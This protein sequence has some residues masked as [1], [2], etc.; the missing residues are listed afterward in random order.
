MKE[1][2]HNKKKFDGFMWD[3]FCQFTFGRIRSFQK[4]SLT[5]IV[6]SLPLTDRWILYIYFW[7][8]S[9]L[10]SYRRQW[11]NVSMVK[12]CH[13]NVKWN[14]I[15]WLKVIPKYLVYFIQFVVFPVY[16]TVTT[17]YSFTLFYN[18]LK[19]TL[20]QLFCGQ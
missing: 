6:T 7:T 1:T 9:Q 18:T 20:R 8:S 11:R 3:L 17:T 19:S 4:R 2:L 5:I 13:F 14:G 16:F 10:K 12:S 15:G